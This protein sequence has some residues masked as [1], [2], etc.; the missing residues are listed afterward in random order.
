M[1]YRPT[2]ELEPGAWLGYLLHIDD[3]LPD[4]REV[5]ELLDLIV[6]EW[7]S[8]PMSVQ[9]FDLRIVERAKKAVEPFR[10]LKRRTKSGP[11][12]AD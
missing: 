1:K 12:T 2:F 5:Y 9:C 7:E 4:E 3:M 11:G 8:D 6:S 10:K